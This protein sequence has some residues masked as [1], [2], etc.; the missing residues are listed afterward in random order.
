MTAA[1]GLRLLGDDDLLA[2]LE[3]HLVPRLG[4]IVSRHAAGHCM[5]MDD[6]EVALAVA[7]VP[8]APQRDP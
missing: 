4:S 7:T 6:I 8:T 3:E 5:R 1:S 2:A